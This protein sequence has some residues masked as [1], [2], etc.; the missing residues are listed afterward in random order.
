MRT[1]NKA[2]L[3]LCSSHTREHITVLPTTAPHRKY[4][5]KVDGPPTYTHTHTHTHTLQ[6]LQLASSSHVLKVANAT[7]KKRVPCQQSIPPCFTS[8]AHRKYARKLDGTPTHTHTHTHTHIHTHTQK[9]FPRERLRPE[10]E[11]SFRA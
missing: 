6:R 4:T 2:W 10:K 3:P 9:R 5:R 8:K 11:W 7:Q 1:H